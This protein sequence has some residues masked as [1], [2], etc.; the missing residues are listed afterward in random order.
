MNEEDMEYVI[1]EAPH[2]HWGSS[3]VF[4]TKEKAEQDLLKWE[5]S[6]E[7][8]LKT[9]YFPCVECG[10]TYRYERSSTESKAQVFLK[11]IWETT[12]GISRPKHLRLC[13]TC[14]ANPVILDK[15]KQIYPDPGSAMDFDGLDKLRWKKG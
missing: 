7:K 3:Y 15:W 5:A 14:A 10:N 1:G 6:R 9:P 2:T 12:K 8:W 11:F 4:S 13:H